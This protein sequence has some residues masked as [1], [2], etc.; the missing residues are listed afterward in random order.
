MMFQLRARRLAIFSLLTWRVF[1]P[2]A[3][4]LACTLAPLACSCEPT[5]NVPVGP[6]I[7]ACRSQQKRKVAAPLQSKTTVAGTIPVSFSVGDSGDAAASI[8]LT[9]P[10]GRAGMQPNVA[11][12]YSSAAG[13]SVVGVGFAISAASLIT[14]CPKTLAIDNELRSVRYDE[15]DALCLDGKR[16]IA[17]HEDGSTI[18]YRTIP[19][20]QIKVVGHFE[21]S[22]ASHFE[23][24][25]PSGDVITFGGTDETRPMSKYGVPRAWLATEQHDPRGNG[26]AFDWCFA[27]NDDDGYVAEFALDQIRYTTFVGEEATQS[28]SFVYGQRD[29]AKFVYSREMQLQHSLRLDEVQM[30]SRDVPARRYLLTYTQSETTERT[31]LTSIEECG[32]D[33]ACKATKFQYGKTSTG[34][35]DVTTNIA[36]P[37]S[38]RASPILADMNGDGLDDW[39][40]P[41]VTAVSTESNPITSWLLSTNTGTGLAAP[42][43]AFLQEWSVQQDP[44]LLADARLI[45]PE[46]GTVFDYNQD[47]R[48]DVLLHD[49]YGNRNNHIV[50]LSRE[51]GTFEELDTGIQRPF[52]IGPAPKN[53]NSPDGAVHLADVTGDGVAD[54][55]QCTN[56]GSASDIG[57]ATTWTLR[58]WKPGGFD[59]NETEIDT[60][61]GVRCSIK[62][63]IVD[64]DHDSKADLVAPGFVK[65]GG[66]PTESTGFFSV[67]RRQSS[68]A[69]EVFD[70]GLPLPWPGGRTLFLDVN[71]DGLPDAVQSGAQDGFLHTFMNTGLGFAPAE[72][73]LKAD[74]PIPQGLYFDLAQP[75]DMDM[76]SNVDL[77]MPLVDSFSPF[78]P[79]WVILRA[80]GGKDGFTFERMDAGIPFEPVLKD[81]ITL[82]D[83]HGP[84]IGD[85]N[86]D[87][88]PDVAIFLD[89]QL[90]LFK[91]KAGDA[92][93]LVGFSDGMNEHDPDE[94]TF[95][96]NV[97]ISYEHL[98]DK[99]KADGA[100]PK[101]TDFY[102][103]Q[104]DAANDCVYP[105]HCAV[106]AK[107]VVSEYRV[108]D[109][110]GG[111]RRYGLRY[112]D[113]RN[114]R[115]NHGFLG[116][117]ERILTDLDTGATTASFYDNRTAVAIG[118]RTVYPFAGQIVSQWRFAPALPT[119]ANK[120]RVELLFADNV[121][122]VVPTNGGQTYFPLSTERHTRR[123]QG[124]HVTNDSIESWA[125]DVEANGN[126]TLLRDTTVDV[127]DWD[128]FGNVLEVDV[129]T[130]GVDLT[131]HVTRT[132][133]NDIERWMLGQLQ[134]QKECST[135]S[136]LSQCRTMTRTT[137]AFGEVETESTSS[138]D[139]IDDTKLT[140][141]YDQRDR[142]GNIEHTVAKDSLGNTRKST[143][144]YDAEGFF[145]AKHINALGHETTLEYDSALGVMTKQIDPNGLS[146]EWVYDS[147]G[148]LETEKRPDGSQTTTNTTREKIDGAWRLRER[149]T[150]TGGADEEAVFDSLGRVI[151]TYSF[152]PQPNGTPAKRIVQFIEYDRLTGQVARKSVPTAEGTPNAQLKWDTYEFDA[153]GREIRHTT[154]WN[155]VTTTK[156]D[157][158]IVDSTDPLSNHTKTELDALGRPVIMMDAANGKTRHAYGPF[159]TLRSVT[160]PGNAVTKWTRDAF[161]RVRRLEEPDR[162]ATLYVNDGFGDV[163]SSTDALGRTVTW[164]RDALGRPETRNDSLQGKTLTTSWT[165]DS[166]PNGIG[167]LH[168]MTSPD[169]LKT[170][171]YTNKG[172][173]DSMT[174]TVGNESFVV[175]AAYDS[176]GRT[177][178]VRYPQPLGQDEFGVTHE[179]D[180]HGNMIAVRDNATGDA[181][182]ELKDV[183]N[184]GRFKEETFGNGVNSMRSYFDDKQT[185]KRI[186]TQFGATTIQALSY[187]WD[188]RLNLKSRADALQAQNKT[189]RFRY[190]ALERLT[191]AYF[192]FVESA[193]AACD[194]S[195]GYAPNGNLTSKSELGALT[196][197]DAKH[198][199]AVTNALGA[200]YGYDAVGNQ[201]TRPGGVTITY[202]PFDLPQTMTQ[203]GKT[204]SFGYD[205]DQ[206]KIRK[207]STTSETIYVD[208]LFEQ[209]T[210]GNAVEL[211]YYVHSPE[212]AIAV[213]TRGGAEPGTKYLHADHLGSVESVTNENGAVVEKRSYDAFGARRNPLWGGPGVGVAGK[214]KK[215]FTGHEEEDE[216]GL[217]NMKGRLF[218]PKVGRFTTTDP[219]IANVFDGQSLGAYAYVRN[220]PLTLIDPSGFVAEPATAFPE[221][222]CC[223]D[224]TVET[225][226]QDD[227][228][229][230][231]VQLVYN[232][233][234]SESTNSLRFLTDLGTTGDGAGGITSTNESSNGLGI[235]GDVLSGAASAYGHDVLDNLKSIALFTVSPQLYMAWQGYR[236]WSGIYDGATTGYAQDGVFGAFAGAINTV[237]PFA[238]AGI[239]VA[240]T[241]DAAEK[242]DYK[243]AGEYGYRSA[244]ALAG[245]AAAAIGV[246][247]QSRVAR[248]ASAP[249]ESFARTEALSG[250][251]ASRQVAELA[252]SMQKEGWQGNPIKVVEHNGQRYVIDGHHRLA[253]ARKVGV[254]VPYETIGSA[255]LTIR[256]YQ[257][258][259]D[260]VRASSEVGPNRLR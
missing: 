237:N 168:T 224:Q 123:K 119:E 62:V 98:I 166:A 205:G 231:E 215:G 37:M 6:T 245:I 207:T 19:D 63:H 198:P 107:R 64:Y 185:L 246:G 203:A 257:T 90:H 72:K 228:A 240:A 190:D 146:T 113:G 178:S 253:A 250:R 14:R 155:A 221:T 35:E 110:A 161:G 233:E 157:G 45:Q 126:A 258:I 23:A 80:T 57:F 219:V 222:F 151:E 188:E 109:G 84:R 39:F 165:W 99:S 137:N 21:D 53:L 169:A 131:Y 158:L 238:H 133:K 77:L 191:C 217:I 164:T 61:A 117:G 36:V 82:A 138:D 22:A 163:V 241:V 175:G 141:E 118:G 25:L 29:D 149:T 223:V 122:E 56:Q 212:R 172:Q 124:E 243:R 134:S 186:S 89:N 160:D 47:G 38:L 101:E 176:F 127:L 104:W 54:L 202:T 59:A 259:D 200:S 17:V 42:K 139:G 229:E 91:N 135:A 105:R 4:L 204:T 260:V 189:E 16:L 43:Q 132:V 50:L 192:G 51:D 86:G 218:D 147:L 31:L 213:V 201:I 2:L 3:L 58:V 115:R 171:S 24:F 130:I 211:R 140:V 114:D 159:D 183:D 11:L 247:G 106:G 70:A 52:P 214:T 78:I 239:S 193:N 232:D 242:G 66:I 208:D 199:H 33:G 177:R 95:I 125:R 102:S 236:F 28:I 196:Y 44:E 116:F 96:P 180:T 49:I 18:E 197:G 156:Y 174:L 69:W 216:F 194:S 184:A 234:A 227:E 10:P 74:L 7:A 100:P 143:T 48:K 30:F 67:H 34:F 187:D 142:Y 32:A 111:Q 87:G 251:A 46:L 27:E 81:A 73:S 5:G 128:E 256:G 145:P 230:D 173:L 226:N 15:F 112:R 255:E 60:L 121:L 167:K 144:V 162:G 108:N 93:V 182:W 120:N 85:V 75:I 71:G 92:D 94:P 68:G 153:L 8:T 40:V 26:M 210:T 97:D 1:T 181:Y 129:A 150:T 79:R 244:V 20:S 88:A 179:Y 154:P 76:D 103:S 55:I 249:A 41:D 252:E 209:V 254:P 12:R 83:P 220:N 152:A 13:E 206:R 9:V 235:M 148:R 195:Y 65:Q 248:Q 225:E 170:Y 136:G